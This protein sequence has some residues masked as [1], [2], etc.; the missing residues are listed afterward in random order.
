MATALAVPY[1]AAT[2]GTPGRQR[3]DRRTLTFTYDYRSNP[4]IRAPTEVVV[5]SYTFPRG[6]T[7]KASGARVLSAENAPIV[8]LQATT[9]AH[10]VEVTVRPRR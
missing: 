4:G 1:P 9:A 8:E 2:A 3:F 10:R 6:Y 7:A 5:P